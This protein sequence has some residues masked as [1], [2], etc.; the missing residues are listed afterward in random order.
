MKAID[1][2]WQALLKVAESLT[3][4]QMTTPDSGGWSPKDNLAHLA[5]W[6]NILLGYHLAKKP[7]HKV[8]GVS[9]DVTRDWNME[10]INPVLF[11]RNKD[12]ARKDVMKLLNK[13]YRKLMTKLKAMSFK[14]LMKPRRADDPKKRPV[15]L[16]VLGDTTD[17]FKEHRLVIQRGLKKSR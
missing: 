3:D 6:M 9:E 10:V 8:I 4:E 2:E 7:A 13:T 11:E 17:H 12:L 16:W 14:D 15:L 5:E 1:H